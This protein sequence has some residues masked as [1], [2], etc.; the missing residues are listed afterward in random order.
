MWSSSMLEG[1]YNLGGE[2]SGHILVLG[3]QYHRRRRDHLLADA[4]A[5]GRKGPTLERAE[6]VMRRLPQVLFNIDVKERK[7]FQADAE[8]E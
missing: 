7:E 4:C 1:N 8:G 5:D 2:Q 6:G 3:S